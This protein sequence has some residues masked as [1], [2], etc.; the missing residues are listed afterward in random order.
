[1]TATPLT[2][3]DPSAV[4]TIAR[5]WLGT[6]YLHQSSVQGVGA[7]CLGLARGIW[8]TLHGDEPWEVPP[9]SRDWGEAGRREVLA[10]AAR[11]ALI[12]ISLDAAGPG[13]LILFRMAPSVPAKHCGILGAS[14]LRPSLIHAYD[15]SGVVEEAFT[16]AWSRRASFAF[17]FPS[18]PSE[19]I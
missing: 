9:Y 16:P 17:Q 5:S 8:R 14:V 6:P 15:R 19:V 10:E 18:A 3:A 2:P 1:M 11:A 7:D 13:T 4:L 12:E